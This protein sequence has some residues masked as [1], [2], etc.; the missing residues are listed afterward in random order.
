MA[1]GRR[2]EGKFW[3]NCIRIYD[4]CTR[5]ALETHIRGP[6]TNISGFIME[7][8][9]KPTTATSR[10]DGQGR[11]YR[12][13]YSHMSALASLDLVFCPKRGSEV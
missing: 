1:L 5:K 2:V 11:V 9:P 6:R 10:E 7:T 12:S 13:F 4:R 8:K 3:R